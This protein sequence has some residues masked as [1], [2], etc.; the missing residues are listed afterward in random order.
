[1][2]FELE[3]NSRAITKEQVIA[4]I[5]RVAK[6]LDSNSLTI[7]QYEKHGCY[8]SSLVLQRCETWLKAVAE[9]GLSTERKNTKAC[10]DEFVPDL[11]RV[12][13]VLSKSSITQQEYR[14]HGRFGPGVVSRHFGG[15]LNALRAA[16]LEMTREYRV[17]NEDY[18]KNLEALWVHLGRQPRYNEV[19]KPLSKY[20]PGAYEHRF[21]SW[22]K[23][24][25]A[26]VQFAEN[27]STSE[28]QQ[29]EVPS[30][31]FVTNISK[32]VIHKTKRQIS[33]R[34]KV[35]VLM[36]DGNQC[37]LCGATV[38]GNDIHF[39]HIKPWSKGGETVLENIQVLCAKHNIAKGD[40]YEGV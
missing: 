23:A 39:D 20:S 12:A 24:L 17:S 5:A 16:D 4:D 22:R 13:T 33:E 37:R 36:R 31:E 1:M 29:E 11:K 27:E 38:T 9:A 10:P 25:E 28:R 2:K 35:R 7:N 34:L 26:F 32:E 15:W 6:D 14:D 3:P 8:K 30:P 21:G 40:F 18:F 19:Q